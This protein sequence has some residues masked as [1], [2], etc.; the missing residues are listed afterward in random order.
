MARSPS[1]PSTADPV[2]GRLLE[3]ALGILVAEGPDALTVRSVAEAA[4]M[5]TMNVYSRF[6]NKKG[7]VDQILIE[8][9]RRLTLSL[10]AA[11]VSNDSVADLRSTGEAYRRFAHDN[12][13]YYSAM[14]S[15]VFPNHER[16][17]DAGAAG[18]AAFLELVSVIVRGVER[19][20]LHSEDAVQ[21]AARVWSTVHGVV[22]LE[23]KA[24]PLGI[25]WD[26]VFSASTDAII[27]ELVT[28]DPTS[29]NRG[30]D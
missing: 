9:F 6:G 21:T 10:E 3:A 20:Q 28:S 30:N 18:D 2:H 13:A 8:G 19:S 17:A 15:N 22:S 5:S 1:Q 7:L 12:P 23:L 24:P 29:R 16:S 26:E 27:R 25:D 11:R 4:G 14:F